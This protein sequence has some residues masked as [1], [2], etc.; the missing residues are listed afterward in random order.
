MHALGAPAEVAGQNPVS[1]T[2]P[3]GLGPGGDPGPR[4]PRGTGAVLW[5]QVVCRTSSHHSE[6]ALCTW[7]AWQC[8]PIQGTS[9]FQTV[10]GR[11]PEPWGAP[12]ASRLLQ[13]LH[14]SCSLRAAR[15]G[16]FSC[17]LFMLL[18]SLFLLKQLLSLFS[19]GIFCYPIFSL[20]CQ[21]LSSA[22]I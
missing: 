11:L 20:F 14:A 3:A 12:A 6:Q 16:L 22:F 19:Y 15:R 7:P 13:E 1:L 18:I 10:W 5:R 21:F 8:K 9:C 4:C 2:L 17:L